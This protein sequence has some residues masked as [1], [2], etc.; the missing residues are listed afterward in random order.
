MSINA[1]NVDY[2]LKTIKERNIHFIRMWFTDALGQMKSFAITPNEL[3]GA[4]EEGMGFDGGSVDGFGHIAESDM[5]SADFNDWLENALTGL[6]E[7]EG[8]GM[9]F[10]G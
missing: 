2:V 4:F 8:F 6:T 3:A 7:K 1:A 9:K 10:V 5:R